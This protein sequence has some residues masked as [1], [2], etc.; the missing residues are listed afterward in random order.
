M[1]PSQLQAECH[2]IQA[3]IGKPADVSVYASSDSGTPAAVF[4]R[5]AGWGIGSAVH[6]F[7]GPDWDSLFRQAEAC[8]RAFVAKRDAGETEFA[9]W[10][11]S[12]LPIAAE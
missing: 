10:F 12:P 6:T 5:P 4:V 3:I 8:A 11:Q 7:H 1:T 9:S 2:R